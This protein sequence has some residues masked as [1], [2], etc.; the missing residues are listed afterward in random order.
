MANFQMDY[1]WFYSTL[2]QS[3]AAMVGVVGMF[4]V[5]RLQIQQDNI[6]A[7]IANMREYLARITT[8]GDFAH[9]TK[10]ELIGK[11]EHEIK[12]NNAQIDK[13]KERIEI[14]KKEANMPQSQKDTIINSHLRT[15]RKNETEIKGY[16][17]RIDNIKKRDEFRHT[18]KSLAFP[19]I[20][21]LVILFILSVIGLVFSTFFRDNPLWG[22]IFVVVI[23]CFLLLGLALLIVCC[24]VSLDMGAPKIKRKEVIKACPLHSF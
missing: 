18:I 23:F 2:A 3:L 24:A 1:N 7:A 9:L 14:I 10:E 5:Y 13:E 16:Q 11:V 20:L 19:T 12:E 6:N 17:I 15:I 21:A 22:N 4:I 8:Q